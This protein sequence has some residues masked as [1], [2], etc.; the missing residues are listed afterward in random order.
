MKGYKL[1]KSIM[2]I[3]EAHNEKQLNAMKYDI[4]GMGGGG[5]GAG[6]VYNFN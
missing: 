4:W 3:K 2:Y 6:V 1:N 5:L